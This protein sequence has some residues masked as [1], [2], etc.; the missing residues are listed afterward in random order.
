MFVTR[1]KLNRWLYTYNKNGG[2]IPVQADRLDRHM[3]I[4]CK[5]QITKIEDGKETVLNI[6]FGIQKTALYG[7]P[8]KWFNAVVVK[9]FGKHP[10][11]LLTNLD[12]EKTMLHR[13]TK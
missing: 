4:N 1:L 9:G 12:P 3:N 10:M 7:K 13:C 6:T 11:V 8:D 5:A 2:I